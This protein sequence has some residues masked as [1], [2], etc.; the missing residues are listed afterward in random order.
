MP[1]QV[2]QHSYFCCIKRNIVASISKSLV[3]SNFGY[4]VG[5]DDYRFQRLWRRFAVTNVAFTAIPHVHRCELS[6]EQRSELA[7]ASGR[8]GVKPSRSQTCFCRTY[9]RVPRVCGTCARIQESG[10]TMSQQPHSS[11][12]TVLAKAEK[13]EQLRRKMA[14]IPARSDG[15]AV[16]TA[17]LPG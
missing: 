13:L 15:P 2:R 8:T 5:S 17:P 4:V 6:E 11:A 7:R 1:I 12:T 10:A 3:D 16:M 14:S 9:V